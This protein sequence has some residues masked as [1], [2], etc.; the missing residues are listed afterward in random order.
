MFELLSQQLDSGISTELIDKMNFHV[1][2]CKNCENYK[3]D[4]QFLII[5]CKQ[6]KH[7]KDDGGALSP[8]AKREII[9]VL[10]QM[11]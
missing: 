8:S 9:D 11:S 10:K 3:K 4:L 5:L 1:S 6:Q 7:T 2:V